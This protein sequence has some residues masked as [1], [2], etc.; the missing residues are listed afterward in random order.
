MFSS[1]ACSLLRKNQTTRSCIVCSGAAV[2]N[3]PTGSI[4]YYQDVLLT[5][6]VM[7]FKLITF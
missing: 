3:I 1:L 5:I 6:F 2:I 4:V 7:A